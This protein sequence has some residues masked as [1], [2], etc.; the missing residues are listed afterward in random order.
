MPKRITSLVKTFKQRASDDVTLCSESA[1]PYQL[2][3]RHVPNTYQ[4]CSWKTEKKK[5][6]NT[7][8]PLYLPN[9]YNNCLQP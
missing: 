4:E 7:P 2:T 6:K 9:A 1:D 5:K 8:V 3:L